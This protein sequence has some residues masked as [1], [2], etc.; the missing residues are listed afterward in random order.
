VRDS[1]RPG[2]VIAGARSSIA[3]KS[4]FSEVLDGVLLRSTE[5]LFGRSAPPALTTTEAAL[6]VDDL[7]VG[8]LIGFDGPQIRGSLMLICTFQAAARSRPARIGGAAQL[9]SGVSR[10]WI[11]V[12][13]WTGELANQ[14]VGRVKNRLLV[15]GISFRIATPVALSGR[16][17]ALAVRK[18]INA[19]TLAFGRGEECIRIVIDLAAE[20]PL[21]ST[22]PNAGVEEAAREG[23]VI[24]F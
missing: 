19:R 7:H 8:A 16:G 15:F 21:T 1:R 9:S 24:E 10:D 22:M 17:L 20:P 13:D 6:K 23:D 14:L 18:P 3:P 4:C 5:E 2:N 11:I 12:R